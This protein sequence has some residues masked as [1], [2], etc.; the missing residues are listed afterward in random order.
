MNKRLNIAL[1]GQAN[2]GKS[3]VFNYLTGLHQHVGNWPGKTVEKAEGTLFYK[4]YEINI[5]DL[6]G[7][8]SLTTYSIEELIAREYI[9]LQKPD[10]IISV[11]D[12][13]NLERN[14]LFVL[15]ILE[16]EQSTI[17]ALNFT[18][19][20]QEKGIEINVEKLE[21]ILGIPAI[22]IAAIYGKGITQVLDRGIELKKI[23]NKE[24][25]IV[26]IRYGKEVER[27]IDKLTKALGTIN[28][29]YPK[30]WL[31][32]K[33][34]EK[35]KEIEKIVGS[36]LPQAME[37][38]KKSI[39]HLEKVHGHDSSIVIAGERCHFVSEI[40]RN[41]MKITKPAEMNLNDKLDM[42]TTDKIWGYPILFFVLFSVFGFIFTFGSWFS[43]LIE[44]LFSNAQII[45]QTSL[46]NNSFAFLGWA[47]IE[48][49]LGLVTLALPYIVPFYFILFLLEDWGYLARV[50]Y[51]TDNL[52]HKL[53][54]HGKACI[55]MLLGFGCNVPAC[56]SCR[57]LET[58]RERLIAGI[59]TS[60]VPCS[61][62]SVII[63]G[64]AGKF[65]GIGWALGFY[66]F[67]FIVI[68]VLGKII[69]EIL[70]GEPTELIM[71]MPDYRKP[72]FKTIVIQT[73]LR[74]KEFIF[75]A[76]PLIIVSGIIIQGLYRLGWLTII[77]KLLSPIT[78]NW[79]GLPA[80]VGILL[81]FGILRKELILVMLATLLGTVNFASVLTPIQ[82]V[83]LTLVSMFYIP[84]IA[85]ISALCK[86]FGL[87]TALGITIFKI[88]FA[89][90]L[91]GIVLRLL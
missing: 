80:T 65:L 86:E 15:Q 6:P 73:W 7:I 50:A 63:F 31:A 43:G 60:F 13:T 70:P 8:Y 22:P 5:I 35:D 88:I 53:G 44:S 37:E 27:E 4:G 16:L 91:G 26:K 82:M 64:I 71:E 58:K 18:N 39:L 83:V 30:R 62:V 38:A 42:I 25:K 66:F 89:I 19:L 57:I 2:V 87:K 21:K 10:F 20:F 33:L 9:A 79:L 23:E 36:K 32:I 81:I 68:L 56:L 67:N 75:I 29:T 55:P 52:M 69:A 45:Y 40:I 61:A 90:A 72:H 41:V 51:L 24:L 59:L 54:I 48:S 28:L 14:L 85:T 11:I 78:V 49:L 3:V 74:L 76:A 84:C 34:L 47:G 77:A 1:V 46:G 12:G 17:I